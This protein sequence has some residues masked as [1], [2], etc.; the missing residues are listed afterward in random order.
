MKKEADKLTYKR[1]LDGS[2]T[3]FSH[4]FDDHYHSTNG[5]IGESAHIFIKGGLLACGKDEISV[6]EVGFG[7]GLNALL[8][9]LSA[10][11][12]EITVHYTA[13][14]K[15]PLREELVSGLNYCDILGGDSAGI[16]NAIT[17]SPW[18]K[19]FPVSK[20]F[21]ITRIEDDLLSY[22]PTETYDL[23]YFDAFGPEKQPE[24]WTDE[25]IRKVA[26]A[27]R[28]GGVFVT[29]SA[30]GSLRR[31]LQSC[32]FA[33]ERLPGPPGKREFTRATRRGE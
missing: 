4:E 25:V 19:P 6:F 18:G 30:R 9:A 16:Y 17:G 14:E 24:M 10:N 31:T 20:F 28:E 7:T 13:I 1:T 22:I 33:T 3:L 5:A 27:I 23:V 11:E 8:T 26:G 21:S 29:Y 32:G 15:Y 12:K 2:D